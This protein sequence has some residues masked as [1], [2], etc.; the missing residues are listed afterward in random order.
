M[1]SRAL[2]RILL[3]LTLLAGLAY[4]QLTPSDD[5][6]T[7]TATPA[8]NLGAKPTAGVSSAA[9]TSFIT[10]DLSPIPAGTTG[11]S[12]AKATLKLYVNTVVTAG[13]FNIVFVNGSWSEKTITANLSPAL[14]AN[15]VGSVPLDKSQVNDYILVDITS[16]L[17]AWLDGTQA[18]DGIA[19]VANSLL[20]ATFDTKENTTNSHPPE[21][22]VVFSGGGTITGIKTAAGSGLIGGANSGVANLSLLRSCSNGQILAWNGSGW[23]CKTVAGT[24]TVTSVG[25]S[26][27]A[28]DFTVSGSPVTTNGTLRLNWTVTPTSVNTAN[29]IVKRDSTGSFSARQIALAT[30]AS[31]A[32][33]LNATAS[34]ANSDGGDFTGTLRGAF[35]LA[36]TNIAGSAG[37]FFLGGLDGVRGIGSVNG[38]DFSGANAGVSAFASG[39]LGVGV[40]GTGKTLSSVGQSRLWTAAAGIW[41]DNPNYGLVATSDLNALVA[42]NNS[43]GATIF[44]QNDTTS[45][46][47]YLLYATA[48]KVTSNGFPATC[49]I[50]THAD[51]G[52]NGDLKADGGLRV[53]QD[54]T[55]PSTANG[56]VKVMF[57]FDP[58]QPGGSQIVRCFNSRLTGAAASTPPCGI[59]VAQI[60]LGEYSF[61]FGFTLE[62]RIIQ[63]TP[64]FSGG[65]I[66]TNIDGPP[67]GSKVLIVARYVGGD[68][69]NARLY[70]TVF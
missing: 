11:A 48:P 68:N 28:A 42:Y 36:S 34:G 67:S 18:N 13:S 19:L 41:A 16:A 70:A 43:T 66:E 69:T 44:G 17:K 9:Q 45:A 35:G 61:D 38:G 20:S 1:T 39:A 50:N 57:Y 14:G 58:F 56:F 60:G 27:P 2:L 63:V 6:Y 53:G 40:L 33:A 22:D 47:G 24:G 26:A 7:D 32:A 59:A 54:A 65:F 10:F 51:L 31:G 3:S 21:L 12:V 46:S 15:I 8:T 25:L 52:C 23:A 4:G 29:A 55:Q 62:S 5:A 37:G 30:S 49:T 64:V